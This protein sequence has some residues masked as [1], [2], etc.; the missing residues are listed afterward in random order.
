MATFKIKHLIVGCNFI[1]IIIEN[2]KGG[3]EV[4]FIFHDLPIDLANKTLDVYGISL[5]EEQLIDYYGEFECL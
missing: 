2:I 3:N 4:E 1:N 5:N